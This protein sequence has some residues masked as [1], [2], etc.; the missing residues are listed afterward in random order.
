MVVRGPCL[1][2]TVD[3]AL[4]IPG[5]VHCALLFFISFFVPAVNGVKAG[6]VP[7]LTV[8]DTA[9]SVGPLSDVGWGW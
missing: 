7:S 4:F 9:G 1:R 5:T 6:G 8:Q 2:C 3:L